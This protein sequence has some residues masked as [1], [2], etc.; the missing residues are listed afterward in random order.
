MREE[1][2]LTQTELAEL[3]GVAMRY[4]QDIEACRRNPTVEIIQRFK[5]GLRCEWGDLLDKPCQ[6]KK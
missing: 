1:K 3:V 5:T 4:I 6:S 2:R